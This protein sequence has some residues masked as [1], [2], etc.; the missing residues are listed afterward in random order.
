MAGIADK[1]H[2]SAEFSREQA[3]V[4]FVENCKAMHESDERLRAD[5]GIPKGYCVECGGEIEPGRKGY[6]R[7]LKCAQAHGNNSPFHVKKLAV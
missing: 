7:C 4:A 2:E 6:D 1:A 5:K 3:Q